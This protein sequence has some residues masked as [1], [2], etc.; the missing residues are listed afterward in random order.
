MGCPSGR[1]PGHATHHELVSNPLRDSFISEFCDPDE[2][3]NS[4]KCKVTDRLELQAKISN[5]KH[6]N[7]KQVQAQWEFKSNFVIA[8]EPMMTLSVK[9]DRCSPGSVLPALSAGKAVAPPP[10]K[11]AVGGNVPSSPPV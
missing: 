11:P 9:S 5:N 1:C 8:L 10:E 6:R 3:M 2:T 4:D 7:K